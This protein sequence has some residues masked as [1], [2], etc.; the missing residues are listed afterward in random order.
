MT[1]AG[2]GCARF[3]GRSATLRSVTGSE[4]A[5]W[6]AGQGLLGLN[7]HRFSGPGGGEGIGWSAAEVEFLLR[8]RPGWVDGGRF[9]GQAHPGEVGADGVGVGQGGDP[10]HTSVAAGTLHG[11]CQEHAS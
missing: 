6:L 8:G 7:R 4:D 5:E 11:I 2:P 10:R 9:G 1:G 3:D